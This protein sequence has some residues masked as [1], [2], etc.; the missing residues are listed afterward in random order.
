MRIVKRLEELALDPFDPRLSK[1]I[2]TA[3]DRRYARVGDW[4]IIYGVDEA[5][6]IP[7]IEAIRPRSGAYR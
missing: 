1:Q 4:R 6:K 2:E 5:A 3:K 7:N